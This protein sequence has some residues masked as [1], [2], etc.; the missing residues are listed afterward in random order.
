MTPYAGFAAAPENEERAWK[1]YTNARF[2]FSVRYPESWRLGN[3]LPDGTGVTLYPP[4]DNSLVALSGHMN[5]L[6]GKSQDGRQ[7]LDEFAIAHRRIITELFGQEND[8]GEV[9][10]GPRNLIGRIS[11]ETNDIHVFGYHA[12]RHDRTPHL[13]TWPQRGS[14]DTNQSA[15][16]GRRPSDAGDHENVGDLSAGTRSER[17]QPSGAEAGLST[18]DTAFSDSA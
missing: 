5:L 2:G 18:D 3:P 12:G 15:S 7:T 8:R 13:F 16:L 1:I 6:E 17:G 4:I 14:R 10:A 11:R 9:A